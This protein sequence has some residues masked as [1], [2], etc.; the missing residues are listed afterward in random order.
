MELMATFPIG[1]LH[2]DQ[3][4]A[5]IK[6]ARGLLGPEV[7]HIAY[8]IRPDSTGDRSIFFRILL[9]DEYI[10]MGG[11][12]ELTNRIGTTLNDAIH[13]IENWGLHPYFNFR[14]KSEQDRK[15]NP[16]WI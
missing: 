16:D 14:S 15:P 1:Y 6:E 5:I 13:P 4:D 3:L 8:R 2:L 11:L 10:Q 12:G 9:A 7:A